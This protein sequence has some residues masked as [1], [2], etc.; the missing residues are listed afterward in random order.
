MLPEMLSFFA[1]DDTTVFAV[2]VVATAFVLSIFGIL[3]F[4]KLVALEP[5]FEAF[6]GLYAGLRIS[7]PASLIGTTIAENY[8][9]L[10]YLNLYFGYL[11]IYKI[12]HL[13]KKVKRSF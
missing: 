10:I 8:Q 4:L 11:F 7:S 6:T 12:H 2:D 13:H 5:R 1:Y 9:L 3:K